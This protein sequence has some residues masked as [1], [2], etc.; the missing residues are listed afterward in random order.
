MRILFAVGNNEDSKND[1]VD[2]VLNEYQKE[3]K[4]I[5]SYKRVFYYNAIINE[6]QQTRDNKYDLIVLSEDLEKNL[7]DS[8]ESE[9]IMLYNHLDEITD[10]GYK[11]DGTSIPVILLCS[12]RRNEGDPIV[13]QLFVLGVYNILI[14]K[15]RT[16]QN[17]CSL[18]ERPNNKKKAKV[19]YNIDSKIL[20]YKHDETKI[21]SDR[22]L[23]SI[24]KFFNKNKEDTDKC[25]RG[26]AKLSREYT[27][28]QLQII[29]NALSLN[30][31]IILEE[32][33]K[34]YVKI[35]KTTVKETKNIDKPNFIE[36]KDLGIE[37]GIDSSSIIIPGQVEKKGVFKML[38]RKQ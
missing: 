2:V 25:V 23:M 21:I 17:V 13:Q 4:K 11:D 14:G 34:E 27:E 7:N 28:E 37:S 26:F 9:D 20:K 38:K 6:L 24:L 5:I 15:D 10:E 22:E 18:I 1:I 12:D 36:T 16:I 8:Y 29:I 35:A 3:Y 31:K 30:T 33:S 32:N 19:R